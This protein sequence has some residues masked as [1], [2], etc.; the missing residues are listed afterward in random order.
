VS[1]LVGNNGTVTATLTGGTAPYTYVWS[2]SGDTTALVINLVEGTH[3]LTLT[4]SCGTVL[5]DSVAVGGPSSMSL[6][7]LP[8]QISCNGFNNG[9]IDLTVSNGTSPLTFLWSTGDTTEDLTGL[10]AGTHSV[11]MIDANGCTASDTVIVTVSTDNCT[12]IFEPGVNQSLDIYPNPFSQT[13]TL[14]LPNTQ[15][16]FTLRLLN[17]SGRELIKTENI[18][19]YTFTLSRGS[20]PSGIYLY[21]LLSG[22]T[23]DTGRIML[24]K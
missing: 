7:L 11:T 6:G 24:V 5:I 17:I 23:V 13:T 15:D 8:T 3:T 16:I 12:G 19:G 2:P 1:C 14:I 10:P 22:A 20:L 9:S 21:R 4:D 18:S